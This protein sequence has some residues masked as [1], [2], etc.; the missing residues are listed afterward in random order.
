MWLVKLPFRILALPIMAIVAVLS[1]FYSH[2]WVSVLLLPWAS[3]PFSFFCKRKDLRRINSSG[4]L[5]Y[6]SS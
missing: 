2:A 5:S 1:I 6:D 3:A 4:P